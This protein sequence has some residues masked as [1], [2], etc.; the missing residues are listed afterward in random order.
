MMEKRVR[1]TIHL[2]RDDGEGESSQ[3]EPVVQVCE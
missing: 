3:K 2:F 1:I